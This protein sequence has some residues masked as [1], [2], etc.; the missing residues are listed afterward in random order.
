[1]GFQGS[2]YRYLHGIFACVHDRASLSTNH[3]ADLVV[4]SR[5][6]RIEGLLAE[7]LIQAG[8]VMKVILI[9]GIEMIVF[10]LYCGSLLDLALLPLFS[11]ATVA[12]RI[13]FTAASPLT[14]LFVHWFVGTCYMFHFALFVSMCRKIL[15]SGVLCKCCYPFD[16]L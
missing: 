11:D 1:M 15:R 3:R 9:I 10:P 2:C 6:Q 14:S 16:R 7:V 12:S 13:A 8:G 5:G 4:P